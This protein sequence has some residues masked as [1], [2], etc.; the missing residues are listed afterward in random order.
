[1]SK[2]INERTI[3]E[4]FFQDPSPR[5]LR[6]IARECDINPTTA[7]KYLDQFI[8]DGLLR[9]EE[10]HAVVLFTPQT[11]NA[12]FIL[13]KKLYNIHRI[14]TSGI[15]QFCD[16]ELSYPAIILFGS[17]AKGEN[18]QKSDIDLFI[19]ASDPKQIDLSKFE[20]ALRSEIQVFVESPAAFKKMRS[21]N[22]ELLNNVLNGVILTGFVEVY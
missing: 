4:L 22:K 19:I 18:H 10:A 8:K 7:S 6:Q 3:L 5:H 15:I 20:K 2:K 16:K 11:S 21:T 14:A 12:L 17:W 13:E 9:K 1:M